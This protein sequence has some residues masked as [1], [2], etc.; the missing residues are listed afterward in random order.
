MTIRIHGIGEVTAYQHQGQYHAW[1][2]GVLYSARAIGPLARLIM[3]G[4]TQ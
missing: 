3:K 4:H 1:H 2:Y